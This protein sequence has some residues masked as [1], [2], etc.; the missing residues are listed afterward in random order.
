MY[1]EADQAKLVYK[2]KSI[3]VKLIK[4]NLDIRF[5]KKCLFKN[6][7]PNYV[8]FNIKNTS[9]SAATAQKVA[10]SVWVK[11]EIKQLY[12]KK[13]KLNN[14]LYHTHLEL[15]SGIHPVVIKDIL[16]WIETQIRNI[17]TT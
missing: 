8:K 7:T 15:L 2:Y 1:I 5:N 9:S 6:I 4:A 16:T 17:I 3:K 12:S 14:D 10:Q 11:E 13:N